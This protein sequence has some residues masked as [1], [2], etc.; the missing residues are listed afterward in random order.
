M[1]I[2]CY[3]RMLFTC[4]TI[5]VLVRHNITWS[6]VTPTYIADWA[7][8]E[9]M[10]IRH[11]AWGFSRYVLKDSLK[12]VPLY[13][14]SLWMVCVHCDDH[15][16]SRDSPS[17]AVCMWGGMVWVRR[18]CQGERSYNSC[19]INSCHSDMQQLAKAERPV[20]SKYHWYGFMVIF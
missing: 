14:I 2:R 13:G 7:M 19:Y 16:M 17:M 3:Q 11:G 15:V 18:S 12:F 6:T 4:P 1:V 8:I 20:R 5:S 10:T 9:V